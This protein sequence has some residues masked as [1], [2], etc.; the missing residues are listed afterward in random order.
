V[1]YHYQ[2]K[3]AAFYVNEDYPGGQHDGSLQHPYSSLIQAHQ[4]IGATTCELILLG[5]SVSLNSVLEFS[6]GSNY[7]IRL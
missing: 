2:A 7:I 1:S 3:S 4:A 5:T 6:T